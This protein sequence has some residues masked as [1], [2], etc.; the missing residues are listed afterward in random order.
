MNDEELAFQCKLP[1]TLSSFFHLSNTSFTLLCL[2]HIVYYA[3]IS[4][5]VLIV[6][7]GA[8]IAL[9]FLCVYISPVY[10]QVPFS[11]Y[12]ISLDVGTVREYIIP[13]FINLIIY[14]STF[15]FLGNILPWASALSSE[16][17][18]LSRLTINLKVPF[19]VCLW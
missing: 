11:Y 7:P 3:Y 12:N 2:R 9:D 6:F 4:F 13:Y 14:S 1:H 10:S 8:I 5:P 15:F 19:P 18:L 17:Y 16:L